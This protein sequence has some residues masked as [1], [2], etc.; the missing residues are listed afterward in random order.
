M[1]KSIPIVFILLLLVSISACDRSAP[2]YDNDASDEIMQYTPFND[3]S[4]ISGVT[5]LHNTLL[6]S[7]EQEGKA[8]LGIIDF[9]LLSDGSISINETDIINKGTE[10]AIIHGVS[11]DGDSY[12]YVL[13]SEESDVWHT[14][15]KLSDKGELLDEMIITD[16][17]NATVR[18]IA[19]GLSGEI[20]IYGVSFISIYTWNESVLYTK[21]IDSNSAVLSVVSHNNELIA[22]IYELENRIT[23]YYSIDVDIGSFNE[24]SVANKNEDLLE[25]MDWDWDVEAM[26]TGWAAAKPESWLQ[27]VSKNEDGFNR[28]GIDTKTQGFDNKFIV[29]DGFRFF[30]L[31]LDTGVYDKLFQWNDDTNRAYTCLSVI[32]ISNDAFIYTI[33]NSNHLYFAMLSN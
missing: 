24:L 7:G 32:Q 23:R 5:R 22:S 17:T 30:S 25:R 21:N 4:H 12:F 9:E 14:L 8:I 31:N 11:T 3:D 15:Q 26:G 16:L 18:G 29:N 19:I 33:H 10:K 28:L 1:N 20:I 6:I 2:N 27:A 13:F